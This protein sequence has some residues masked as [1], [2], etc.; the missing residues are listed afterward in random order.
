MAAGFSYSRVAAGCGAHPM[1]LAAGLG[2]GAVS[3]GLPSRLP[4]TRVEVHPVVLQ[5]DDQ[6]GEAV[7]RGMTS[8]TGAPG[9]PA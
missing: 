4:L 5:D 8:P 1:G 3:I 9:T 6:G 2:D 7:C